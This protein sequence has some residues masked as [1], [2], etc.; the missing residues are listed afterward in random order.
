MMAKRKMFINGFPIS[1]AT[2]GKGESKPSIS[3]K[4]LFLDLKR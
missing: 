2:G 1:F 4:P 3:F